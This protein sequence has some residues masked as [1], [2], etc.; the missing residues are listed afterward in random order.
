MS[1]TMRLESESRLLLSIEPP[2][3]IDLV[4][5][6]RMPAAIALASIAAISSSLEIMSRSVSS[7]GSFETKTELSG[8]SV[9]TAE[10]H[11]SFAIRREPYNRLSAKARFSPSASATSARPLLLAT[12]S[13]DAPFSWWVAWETSF[14]FL[15]ASA[16]DTNGRGDVFLKKLS[17]SSR[18]WLERKRTAPL[19][20]SPCTPSLA[21]S[22]I[23]SFP[24]IV[25][26]GE[27]TTSQNTRRSLSCGTRLQ[28]NG[29]VLSTGFGGEGVSGLTS[30]GV[31]MC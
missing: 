2:R 27:S 22:A 24:H 21:I 8:S 29:G 19:G 9:A 28:P 13:C 7:R 16:A 5:A 23:V 14:L 20:G 11:S 18:A 4:S 10:T 6:S 15:R 17:S 26:S 3:L 31:T 1:E 12:A 30:D 25:P